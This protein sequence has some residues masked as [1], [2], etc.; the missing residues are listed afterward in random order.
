MSSISELGLPYSDRVLYPLSRPQDPQRIVAI[1]PPL[2]WESKEYHPDAVNRVEFVPSID[3]YKMSRSLRIEDEGVGVADVNDGP[4]NGYYHTQSLTLLDSNSFY[5]SFDG[6]SYLPAITPPQVG[7][8]MVKPEDIRENFHLHSSVRYTQGRL[9]GFVFAKSDYYESNMGFTGGRVEIG[10]EARMKG[11]AKTAPFTTLRRGKEVVIPLGVNEFRFKA[12]RN[13]RL[14]FSIDR[15]E[16]AEYPFELLP[17]NAERLKKELLTPELIE[18][19]GSS[20]V[21]LEPWQSVDLF[22]VAGIEIA[23]PQSKFI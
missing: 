20:Y 7:E 12:T 6:T 19:P 10:T 9:D 16:M 5:Y 15:E 13:G 18:K 1:Y 2:V 4:S 8:F 22:S 11:F 17:N 23:K 3:G 14:K 21:S